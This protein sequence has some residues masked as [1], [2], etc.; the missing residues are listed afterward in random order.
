MPAKGKIQP[1]MNLCKEFNAETADGKKMQHYSDLL[2]KAIDN[3][4]SVKE[5][6]DID[7]LFSIGETTA[8]LGD[9]KGLDD[10]EL[11]TFLVIK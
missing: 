11:I 4:I 9:I 5:E 7:S 1:E 2:H 3:I 10:F 6:S 8:L